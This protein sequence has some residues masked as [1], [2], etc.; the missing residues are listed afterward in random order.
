[1]LDEWDPQNTQPAPFRYNLVPMTAQPPNPQDTVTVEFSVAVGDG[2]FKATAVV[3]AGQTNLT[4]IL[5]VIQS[6]DD[7]FIQGV[8]AQLAQAGKPV[9]CKAGCTHCCHQ[10]ISLNIFE[11]EALAA[12]IQTLP[13]TRQKQLADRF[14]KTLLKI[15]AAELID[16]MVDEDWFVESSTAKQLAV[17]YLYKRIPCPFLEE[18][19][20]SIYPM[21]PLICREYM[22]TSPPVHCY[23]PVSLQTEPVRMPLYFSRTLH[24][25]AAELE[26]DPRGWIPLVFLFG[27]MKANAHPGECITGDG[28]EVLYEF[29]KRIDRA[30]PHTPTPE[31]QPDG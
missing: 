30:K 17:D 7:S 8:S 5:P 12:W 1:L 9:S 2:K 11:A 31:P 6:L 10:L 25:I 28:P 26:H 23:D 14:H 24:S 29:I 13:E 3:P 27:W 16:R 15:S 20:C 18:E 22:V 4:Q 19:R 21:R